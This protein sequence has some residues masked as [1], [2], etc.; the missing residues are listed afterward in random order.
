MV[1][2]NKDDLEFLLNMAGSLFAD[3]FVNYTKNEYDNFERLEKKYV[4]KTSKT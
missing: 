3:G 1:E 2:I 4:N